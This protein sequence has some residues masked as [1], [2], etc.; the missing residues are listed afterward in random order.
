[1]PSE[2]AR[3]PRPGPRPSAGR[4]RLLAVGPAV[5]AVLCTAAVALSLVLFARPSAAAPLTRTLPG[6][7]VQPAWPAAGQAALGIAGAGE[8]ASPGQVPVPTASTAKL[9]TAYVFL[10]RYPLRPGRPGPSFTVSAEEAARHRARAARSE[11]VVPL[12][13]GQRLTERQALSA[14]LAAS[15]N[16]VADEMARWYGPDRAAFVADMN[17]TAHRLGM[18]HTR[19]TDPSG[20]APTTVSTAADQVRLL[21]AALKTPEF[22]TLA[23]ASYTD[24]H[25]R[26]HANTNPVLGRY[27]VFAGKT[28]TTRAA[29]RNLV[30]A[31]HRDIAGRDRLVVGA[32]LGQPRT[33][34]L[35]APVRRL[36]TGTDHALVT[37]PVVRKGEVLAWLRGP[38]G[39]RIA[40]RAADALSVTGPP[41]STVHLTVEPGAAPAD[42][43]PAGSEAARLLLTGL[44]PAPEEGGSAAAAGP[45]APA[46]P[47]GTAA[48]GGGPA[49]GAGAGVGLVTAERLP[50]LPTPPVFLPGPAAL[51]PR[52]LLR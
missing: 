39:H 6:A 1:M 38:S 12:L 48:T 44:V 36:L 33:S 23:G 8:T 51:L 27:G 11:S 26:A 21:V 35:T 41:G 9:M 31:A 13:K 40:L 37:A 19:Y 52:F 45:P 43:A 16:N 4:R 30:F 34:T 22:G 20:L 17:S 50:R 42:G 47:E 10:N 46:G 32:V 2:S 7:P 29:G 14:L 5:I 49:G 3:P 28:G 15:A 18:R 25:G 24:V